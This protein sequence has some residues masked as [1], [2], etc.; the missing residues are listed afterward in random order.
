MAKKKTKKLEGD[1]TIPGVLSDIESDL[2]ELESVIDEA[3]RLVDETCV[4]IRFLR[5]FLPELIRQ[6]AKRLDYGDG[7]S[8]LEY[9]MGRSDR[10][11]CVVRY[12][13]LRKGGS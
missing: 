11:D 12:W 4:K 13:N 8:P 1:V 10:S 9:E 3:M 2:G 7:E 5:E 6:E